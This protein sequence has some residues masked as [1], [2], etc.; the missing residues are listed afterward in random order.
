MLGRGDFLLHVGNSARGV[1]AIAIA[2]GVSLGGSAL[3]QQ[4]I[5]APGNAAVTGF[6]GASPPAQIAPGIDPG[7]LTFIDGGGP[8]LRIVDLQLMG[9]P[10]A[11]QLVGAPKPYTWLANQIGQVFGV[12]ADDA[13]PP[14]IYLAA[15]SAYGLPIVAPGPDGQPMHI[16]VGAPNATF[17]PGLWGPGGGPGSIWKIDGT[18]GQ[19]TLFA[20]VVLGSRTNSGAALGGL[21]FDPDSKSL[22][23]SDRE[24]GFIHRFAMN[25][26]ELGRYGHGVT[27]RQALGMPPAHWDVPQRID[28]TSP[29]FDSEQPATWNY[30]V[31]ERRVYGLAVYQHRLY[32]AIADGLQIWSVGLQADGSF[33]TDAVIE[34]VVPP[35]AGPTE[36]SKITFDEQGRMYLAERPAPTGAYDFEAL[37]QPGVGR[38]LRY[39]LVSP[40]G[41]RVWQGLPDSY[42]IGF[43]LALHNGNGGAAIGYRY[44]TSGNLSSQSCGGFLWST[45]EDLRDSSDTAL[46]QW[47]EKTGPLNVN[48]LQGNATWSI[49]DTPPLYAYFVAYGDEIGD[50]G[51]RGYM[52]DVAI[53]PTCAPTVPGQSTFLPLPSGGQPTVIPPTPLPN[54]PAVPPNTPPNTPPPPPNTPP[55]ASCPS[56]NCPTG[57]PVLC[58]PGQ[59]R[60]S[61]GTCGTCTRPSVRVGDQCCSPA[62]LAPGGR[63]VKNNPGCA[64]G[65][66]PVGPS[67]ACCPSGQTYSGS[68]GAQACCLSGHVANGQCLPPPPTN[69]DCSPGSTSPQC[70][71][72]GYV[73]TGKSC[74]LAGQM[75]SAGTCCPSGQMPG[76]ANKNQCIPIVHI[77][78][79]PQCCAAGQ[80]PAKGGTCCPAANV[81]TGG[82]C[83]SGPVDPR[84]RSTCPAITHPTPACAPGYTKMPDGSCCNNR[85]VGSDG[86]S[87]GVGQPQSCAPGQF[88]DSSG[89]CQTIPISACPPG[90]AHNS[91]GT[92]MPS[93]TTA[94]PAGEER[95]RDGV[96]VAARQTACLSG[97]VRN[98]RGECVLVGPPPSIV[99]RVA[100]PNP[101]GPP[102][103]P[104]VLRQRGGLTATPRA[105]VFRAP[106]GGRNIFHH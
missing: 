23:V 52:G 85:S 27:G 73:S 21:A 8:S 82:A 58:L 56:G 99:G 17:M 29:Q 67:N 31:P 19:V 105:P 6:S 11:A 79:G 7:E 5:L 76:G 54:I 33:D 25:G 35:A 34:F 20:N 1:A 59:G 74:C 66:T 87:C 69:P 88:L 13:T 64:A 101:S 91:D 24:T 72:K 37:T 103:P 70:C 80:I 62:D 106:T 43:P 102:R 55:S 84:N 77:P 46:A 16:K 28:I 40:V 51:S 26:R 61:A 98:A 47:L 53:V 9:G 14:N 48:G 15:T 71:S 4:A 81:T 83:C 22:F 38:V 93:Q 65:E 90:R 100:H 57:T 92:C 30:A 18:T 10:P 94:C 63:C 45:G 42:A 39:A 50:A 32:Y 96:C 104:F 3:A 75:T 41:P 86:K 60:N 12:V 36:I 44:D 89:V 2:F 68:N 78:V 49:D 97:E 95:D